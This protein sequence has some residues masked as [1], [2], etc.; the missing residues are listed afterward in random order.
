MKILSFVLLSVV[1]LVF[2]SCQKEDPV[3]SN[4]EEVITTLVYT[5][6][7]MGGGNPVIFSFADPDGDGGDAPVLTN[8]ILQS[9]TTYN[10]VLTL[11]NE[12]VK[13]SEEVHEEV[14]TEAEEHQLFY[15]NTL[16]NITITYEDQDANGQALGLKTT[17]VTGNAEQGFLTIILR[18]EPNKSA[19]GVAIDNAS[20]AGGETDIEVKFNVDIQ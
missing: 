17:L 14:A 15:E 20:P 18:H 11:F 19:A 9:N 12:T 16:N 1:L 8:G 6:T 13:P 5:L 4:E 2:A 3:I 10:G 7:P